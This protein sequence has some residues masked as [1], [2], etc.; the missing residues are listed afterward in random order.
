MMNRII[1]TMFHGSLRAKVFLWSVFVMILATVLLGVFAAVMGS[2]AF[3]I[4]A[5]VCGVCTL[6]T[7]QSVSLSELEKGRRRNKNK[8]KKEKTAKEKRSVSDR[9]KKEKGEEID[10]GAPMDS[11]EREKAK[12]RYIASMNDKKMKQLMKEHK[13]KQKHIFVMI[14]SYPQERISQTPGIMWRTDHHLHILAMDHKAIEFEVPLEDIKGIYYEKG[15][16]ADPQTDYASFQYANFISKL[17]KPY[18][19]EYREMTQDGA[20]VHVKNIFT[21]EPGISFTNTSMKGILQILTKVPLLVD[22]AVNTSKHFDEYFKEVYRYSILCKNGVYTLEE[23]REKME[24]VLNEL[25][26]APVTAKEFSKSLRDM[27]RYRLITSDYVM[28]YS[29]RYVSQNQ[30][31]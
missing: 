26:T 24:G 2:S 29:Q 4:G 13:I 7:S 14:D 28:K 8:K 6:I 30:E 19:P 25:L 22:D 23:Y 21:I 3:G 12:A 15:V 16:T 5:F 1:N 31:K 18:L 10:T 11:K 27:N 20:L 17:Y 9:A